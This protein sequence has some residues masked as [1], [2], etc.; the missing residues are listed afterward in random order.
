[1]AN[2]MQQ[3]AQMLGVEL[4]EEFKIRLFD[5]TILPRLYK[6]T[7]NGLMRTKEY[8]DR[9]TWIKSGRNDGLLT[10]TH[11]IVK[12]PWKPKN[13]DTYYYIID[14]NGVWK[15]GWT[16]SLTDLGFFSIGNCFRTEQ[17]AEEAA[18]SGELLAKLRKYYDEYGEV[19]ENETCNKL[20]R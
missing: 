6:F 9:N 12:M 15:I 17:E 18:D 8:D 16:D 4:G 5:G 3:V 11:E 1:M 13:G 19:N 14:D 7:E 10:G 2:Y 20:L